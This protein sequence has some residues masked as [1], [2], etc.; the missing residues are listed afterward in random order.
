MT[1]LRE[2]SK[3]GRAPLPPH[4]AELAATLP[5]DLRALIDELPQRLVD[6]LATA[7]AYSDR[8]SGA[9]LVSHNIVPV[10]YRSLETW[11]LPWQHANGRAV[12]PTVALFAV[13]Y[14]KLTA[15]PVV[16]GGRH[17]LAERRPA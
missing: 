16:M 7:P 9:R 4:L 10:S 13:A 2:M 17:P 15:A 14:G 8:R 11:P 3:T 6:V 1:P 12:T 5:S